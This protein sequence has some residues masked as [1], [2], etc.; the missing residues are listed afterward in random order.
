MLQEASIVPRPCAAGVSE[1]GAP[2]P[3]KDERIHSERCSAPIDM[4][5]QVDEA[6][7]NDEPCG[8]LDGAGVRRE[9]VADSRHASAREGNS[10][11]R[12]MDCDG[13][14]T[15]PPRRT[16]SNAM[17]LGPPLALIAPLDAT[18]LDSKR[19]QFVRP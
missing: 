15:R 4:R 11:T 12:S 18:D 3:G 6:R 17:V 10:V 14:M 2:A 19:M 13:S 5:M 8:I 9:T 1:R 7:R 16:R